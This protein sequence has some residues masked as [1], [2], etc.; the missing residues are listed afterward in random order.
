M[1]VKKNKT[2]PEAKGR[3]CILPDCMTSHPGRQYS[4]QNTVLYIDI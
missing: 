3:V 1:G 4:S 2:L